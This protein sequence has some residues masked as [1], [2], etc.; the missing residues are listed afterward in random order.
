MAEPEKM[1]ALKK[2][3]A[4]MIL[5][6]AKEAASRVMTSERKALRFQQDLFA[7][8]S[9]AF[10]LLVHLKQMIDAKA[11]EA[12]IS[13]FS[14][15]TKIDELEAQLQ[16]AE[17]VIVDL[18]AELKWARDKL[19][20]VRMNPLNGKI[21]GPELCYQDATHGSN[22]VSS[23]S[24]LQPLTTSDANNT[25]FEPRNLDATYTNEEQTE[26]SSVS[27][28]GSHTSYDTGSVSVSVR[29]KEP[30]LNRNGC[31]QRVPAVEKNLLA[32]KLPPIIE[33]DKNSF[34][35]CESKGSN[36]GHS[37]FTL[38]LPM[39][40]KNF[41]GEEV[42][43]LVKLRILRRRTH[44][45]KPKA[46]CR[47]CPSQLMKPRQRP[48]ILSRCIRYLGK[49][50]AVPDDCS[51]PSIK[52]D[53]VDLKKQSSKTGKE[54]HCHNNYTVDEKM[55]VHEGNKQWKVHSRDSLSTS[56]I[57]YPDQHKTCQPLSLLVHCHPSSHSLH[58][59]KIAEDRSRMSENEVKIKPLTRLDP[60]LTLIKGGVDPISGSTNITVSVK[61][62]N[63]SEIIQNTANKSGELVNE[64][65]KKE[66]KATANTT[67]SC[68]E[69]N[70]HIV[71]VPVVYSDLKDLK[72]SK[73]GIIDVP[74]LYSDL[75]DAKSKEPKTCSLPDN[76]RLVKYTFQRKRKKETSN[77]PD[78]HAYFEKSTVKRWLEE[79]HNGSR[80]LEKSGQDGN[81]E[82]KYCSVPARRKLNL[83]SI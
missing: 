74:I 31:T 1:V 28:L 38:P 56:L 13:S 60:G 76:N 5:N 81:D 43:K 51:L 34:M 67:F 9:E 17:G 55:S 20:K 33:F 42:R 39:T 50:N 78:Q 57:S 64:L 37:K 2:A 3:Y 7:A 66:Y 22:I 21:T 49:A 53:S 18:R 24:R 25:F 61:A 29:N 73:E 8:K 70:P 65:V 68:D 16:E 4:D 6:T 77:S 46:K 58:D 36:N 63:R 15:Q 83:M 54:L 30:E 48:S 79:E 82:V 14:Q 80:E 10:R 27:Q 62:L 40:K 69:L 19:E 45:R 71:N 59:V 12:E 32:G 52:T 47:S 44:F 23:D 72:A 11:I 35:K 26:H 75:E 41:T